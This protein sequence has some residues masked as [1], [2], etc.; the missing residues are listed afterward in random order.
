MKESDLSLLKD[1]TTQIETPNLNLLYMK[2]D[3]NQRFTSFV[4]RRERERNE[5]LLFRCITGLWQILSSGSVA[6]M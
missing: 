4:W 3:V 5:P 6:I 1:V 2:K